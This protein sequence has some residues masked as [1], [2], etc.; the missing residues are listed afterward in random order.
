LKLIA[1]DDAEQGYF[2]SRL[3]HHS[4]LMERVANSGFLYPL[5]RCE[6]RVNRFKDDLKEFEV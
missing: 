5:V 6:K 1:N 3:L 4:F 2:M